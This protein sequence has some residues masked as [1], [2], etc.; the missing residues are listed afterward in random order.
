MSPCMIATV[1]QERYRVGQD[2]ISLK[3]GAG[4]SSDSQFWDCWPESIQGHRTPVDCFPRKKTRQNFN[5]T[6]L[7]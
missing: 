5:V 6:Y 3:E 2:F 1:Q 7:K 4:I